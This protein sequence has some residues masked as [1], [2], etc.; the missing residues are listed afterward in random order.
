MGR[1]VWLNLDDCKDIEL[2]YY[3]TS[4]G[5]RLTQSQINSRYVQ[6]KKGARQDYWCNSCGKRQAMD[7]SHTISQKRCKELHKTELIWDEANWSW[8]CRTCHEIWEGY[9][10][11]EF[12]NALNFV[13]RMKY[14]QRRDREGF[15]KRMMWVTDPIKIK[16]IERS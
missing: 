13:K 15:E 14:I 6:A 8:D 2:N 4:D 12:Q 3:H 7:C 5:Q 9:K 16:E 11:G 1:A 10:S